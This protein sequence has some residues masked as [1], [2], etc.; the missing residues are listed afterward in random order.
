MM[1]YFGLWAAYVAFGAKYTPDV[2][3]KKSDSK[4]YVRVKCSLEIGRGKQGA[5]AL[6]WYYSIY[7]HNWTTGASHQM[8]SGGIMD[9]ETMPLSVVVLAMGRGAAVLLWIWTIP[10]IASAGFLEQNTP[11]GIW[12]NEDRKYILIIGGATNSEKRNGAFTTLLGFRQSQNDWN[13]GA[14]DGLWYNK[15]NKYYCLRGGRNGNEFRGGSF[16]I[17]TNRNADY[18]DWYIGAKYTRCDLV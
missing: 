10:P 4:L 18:G 9:R 11:D 5:A 14:P 7:D 17:F 15:S 12:G 16:C 1:L 8:D 2:L 3:Q 6:D 13:V